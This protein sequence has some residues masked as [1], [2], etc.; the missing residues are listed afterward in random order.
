[1]KERSAKRVA[2]PKKEEAEAKPAKVKGKASK[3][4]KA[5]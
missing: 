3:G 2:A 5:A 1:M 4:K